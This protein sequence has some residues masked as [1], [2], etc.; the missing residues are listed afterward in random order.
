MAQKPHRQRDLHSVTCPGQATMGT[1]K[2]LKGFWA[3]PG[4]SQGLH[5]FPATTQKG[6][7]GSSVYPFSVELNSWHKH[8]LFGPGLPT[9]ATK[10][11]QLAVPRARGL[12][13]CMCTSGQAPRPTACPR[14]KG[15]GGHPGAVSCRLRFPRTSGLTPLIPPSSSL[16]SMGLE[17][18][19]CLHARNP[20]CC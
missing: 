9:A 7:R 10:P 1:I 19:G 16:R 6:S 12:D 5:H 3:G 14:D 8:V 18:P 20:C 13:L 17:S 15:R 2:A 4:D 11:P